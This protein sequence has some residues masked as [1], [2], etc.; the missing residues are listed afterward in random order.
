MRHAII[1]S[2][3]YLV[4]GTLACVCL[5]LT[6]LSNVLASVDVCEDPDKYSRL[7]VDIVRYSDSTFDD[8]AG[9]VGQK[10]NNFDLMFKMN[11]DKYLFG[12][13]HRYSIFDVDPLQPQT[14][15]HL[16]TFFLPLHKL[17]GTD[18]RSFRASIAP[19]L[20]AS[21]NV[22][23]NR[24]ISNDAF[25]LLVALV[26]GR[27][28]SERTSL[29]YGICGDHRFG[30][31]QIYPV[32]SAQ[33][34]PHPDWNIQLGFPTS[35]L[36]YQVSA[37]FTSMIRITPDG[38]E[39]YVLDRTLANHSQFVYESFALEWAFDWEVGESFA[40]TASVGR[41]IDNRFEMT[42]VDQS[43]VRL[44]SDSVTR[45]GAALEWRF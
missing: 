38:N 39:W 24:K 25:Q 23:D 35:W 15:G 33:W 26:W 19:A 37:R 5:G 29:R 28:L 32:I 16:H 10:N 4:R 6:G 21:S 8:G 1:K 17:T 14:N 12:A 36:S 9:T 40:I 31:Y 2:L 11:G 27:R 42:L 43:R 13:G 41:Q 7:S 18:Q 30:D 45:V 34:Q 20:S 3:S 22:F 44:S